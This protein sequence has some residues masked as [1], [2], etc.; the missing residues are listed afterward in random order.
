MTIDNVLTTGKL[1]MAYVVLFGMTV[2]LIFYTVLEINAPYIFYIEIVAI[3]LMILIYIL[4]LIL[5]MNYF[6]ISDE[7]KKITI[8]YYSAHPIFRKY[9]TFSVNLSVFSGYEI[10]KS[11]FGLRRELILKGKNGKEEFSFP[12]VSISALSKTETDY[13]KRFLKRQLTMNN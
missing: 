7:A 1:K 13:L 8:R 6:Y 5:K 10:R 3:V 9:K 4:L 2:F 11:V 12:A